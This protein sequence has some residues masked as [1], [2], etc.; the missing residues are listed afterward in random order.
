M[1]ACVVSDDG[2]TSVASD[3]D[4]DPTTASAS[5]SDT[6]SSAYSSGSTG[7]AT[8]GTDTTDTQDTATTGEQRV[9]ECMAP[10]PW[11]G[12]VTSTSSAPRT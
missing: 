9:V 7:G 5:M 6:M 3:T 1:T 2:T 8:D 10:A 4:T 11:P 12:K